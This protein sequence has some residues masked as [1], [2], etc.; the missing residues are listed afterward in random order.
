MTISWR[1]ESA[2]IARIRSVRT[3]A[4][5]CVSIAAAV[6]P[7]EGKAIADALAT[8]AMV[9][10]LVANPNPISFDAGPLGNIDVSGML[11]GFTSWQDNQVATDRAARWDL[12]NAQIVVQKTDGLVQFYVQ[13]GEYNILSLGTPTVSTSYFTSH[14]FGPVPQAYLK[15]APT[16]T[17]NIEI[18]KLPTLIGDED[19]FS[20][21]NPNMERGLGWNQTNAQ[22]RGVQANYTIGPVALN[23]S[24]NDGYYS[25]KYNWI[26][27]LATWT[28][29]PANTLAFMGAGNAGETAESTF[30]TPLLQNNQDIYDLMYT[31]AEGPWTLQPY[32]QYSHVPPNPAIGIDS[33]GGTWTGALLAIY[34]ITANWNLAGRLEYI[35]TSGGADMLY[36]PRS[37]A[38]SVTVTPTF[39]YKV[40]FVRAEASYV[41][42]DH[43]TPF[44]T[45]FGDN[46]TKNNQF[47][48]LVETGVIF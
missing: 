31:H 47:R 21:Q 20:F 24:W 28:I 17:F 10:P 29:D 16:D 22:T 26:S 4:A 12:S 48:A 6:L 32:L 2:T 41:G 42:A 34:N 7:G 9:G 39:Q 1:S 8:P 45:A 33:S 3:I 37:N 18:G 38:W 44:E 5:M 15:L 43:T 35:G 25:D 36:G 19:T 14:A 23:L 27:G 13:A 30:I 46:G 11:A 40:F